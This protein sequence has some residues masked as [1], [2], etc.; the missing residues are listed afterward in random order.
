MEKCTW[1]N[2]QVEL[3]ENMPICAECDRKEKEQMQKAY[4]EFIEYENNIYKKD[5]RLLNAIK[6]VKGESFEKALGELIKELDRT[7]DY[8]I[9][10]NPTG[11]Y[12]KEYWHKEI[13]GVWVDQ[14]V[15]GGMEGDSFE[16]YVY[17][18]IKRKGKNDRYLKI[19]YSM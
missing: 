9:V 2:K 17:V 10:N 19:P 18:K 14:Y 16:G 5:M 1:C 6:S 15:N 4:A 3:L 12:Q 7:F 11:N 8:S 13:R